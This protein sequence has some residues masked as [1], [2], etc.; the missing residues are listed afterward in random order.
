M[1]ERQRESRAVTRV[2]QIWIIARGGCA[3]HPACNAFPDLTNENGLPAIVLGPRRISGSVFDSRKHEREET[4][5]VR[6]EHEKSANFDV[7]FRCGS[8]V[9]LIR[10]GSQ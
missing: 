9:C 4:E 3:P 2:N 1:Y 8:L 5:D 10:I 7:S 6:G